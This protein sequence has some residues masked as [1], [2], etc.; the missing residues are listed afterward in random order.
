M[1]ANEGYWDGKPTLS[2]IRRPYVGDASTRLNMYKNGDIDL[3]QLER[4]DI[5]GLKKDS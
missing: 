5:E 2:E 4:A 1:A 3:V